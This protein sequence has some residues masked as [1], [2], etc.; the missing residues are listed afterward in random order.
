MKPLKQLFLESRSG[1]QA[2]PSFNID[3]YEIFQAVTAAVADTKLPCLVQL[4]ANED[5]FI[6]AEN[7]Y[8]L[9]KKANL[10]GL[11]IYLNMDH[12]HDLDR[13]QTL[14]KLG[15]DMVHFDGSFLEYPE[16]LARSTRFIAD[17]KA[18]NPDCLV[19]VEFNKIN[20][21]E[22]GVSPDSLTSPS[23]AKE[24]I[25]TN[26]ADLLAVSIGNL[27][28]ANPD[29]PEV[30][31]LNL[32]KSIVDILPDT[33]FTLHGGSGIPLDLVR[34][35][36]NLGIV[37]ININTDLRQKF[38]ASLQTNLSQSSSEKI[39]DYFQPVIADVKDVIIK[40][41]INFSSPKSPLSKG[42]LGGFS[43]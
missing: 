26:H 16:N 11:P 3:S 6:H 14:V 2:I 8:L 13:L 28:G 40:K 18:I 37:K 38:K 27:H 35:A 22:A 39:Y 43:P 34:S 42:D 30:I 4:S 1:H 21:T 36:I 9:V 23:Q 25:D 15:F 33:F 31:D 5:D 19:E 12:G 32:F 17:I 20:L 41:L 29:I 7:L 10:D 24:F